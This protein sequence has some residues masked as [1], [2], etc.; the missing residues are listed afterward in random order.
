MPATLTHDGGME[1][2]I[3]YG[4]PSNSQLLSLKLNP[5]TLAGIK[6]IWQLPA[7]TRQPSPGHQAHVTLPGHAR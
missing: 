6:D 7:V 5:L 1:T 2:V 4:P 3:L